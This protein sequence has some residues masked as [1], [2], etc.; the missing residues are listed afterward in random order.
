MSKS[1]VATIAILGVIGLGVSLFLVWANAPAMVAVHALESRSEEL[2]LV[3]S[4][5][6]CG[7]E[8]SIDFSETDREVVVQVSDQ[9]FR[10]RLSGDDCLDL[11]TVALELPLGERTLLDGSTGKMVT[12]E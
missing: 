10:I 11:V 1:A 9:R 2:P 3:I 6:T 4:V 7:G 8:L 12:T 5:E